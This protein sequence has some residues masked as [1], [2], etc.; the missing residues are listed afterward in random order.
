MPLVK[1]TL[2]QRLVGGVGVGLKGLRGWKGERGGGF[3]ALC[4][5]WESYLS[6]SNLWWENE[7]ETAHFMEVFTEMLYQVTEFT[8][9]TTVLDS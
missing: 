7:T 5:T 2:Q 1:E 8:R 3:L 9:L 4:P 6:L